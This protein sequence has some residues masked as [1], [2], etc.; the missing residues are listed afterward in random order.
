MALSPLFW[1]PTRLIF[2]LTKPRRT[3]PGA[4]LAGEVV[5]VG[6]NVTRFKEGGQVF[7][8][9]GWGSGAHAEYIALPEA[10][11]LA[12]KPTN[13]TYEEAAAVTFG[14][15]TALHFLR[16]ADIKSGQQVLIYGASGSVGTFAV[17]LA[18][19]FGAEVTGVCSIRN[20]EMVRSLGADRVID[21]TGKDFTDDGV[22]YDVIFDAVN[23]ILFSRCQ[24]S[25]KKRG[26]YLSVGGGGL[27]SLRKLWASIV[28]RKKVIFG[29]ANPKAEDLIFLKEPIEAGKLRSVIDRSYPLADIAEAH[30]YVEAGHKK[31][32]VVITVLGQDG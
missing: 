30:R 29:I 32:N 23:K 13:I 15:G 14:G 22:S 9:P 31:G 10:G 24:S 21:Y 20:L 7:G 6:K 25:L 17:Q 28:S 27:L 8:S 16:K 3:I 18:K 1:L 26:V 4:E 2:G 11:L 19:Y 5:A 12:A